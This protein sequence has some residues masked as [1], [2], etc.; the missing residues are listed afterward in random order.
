MRIFKKG[1]HLPANEEV[2]LLSMKKYADEKYFCGNYGFL[3]FNSV[4]SPCLN[5]VSVS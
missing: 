5:V 1:S 3:F 4:D 2:G